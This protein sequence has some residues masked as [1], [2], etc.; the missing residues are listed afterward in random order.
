[1]KKEKIEE[2]HS[3][4]I[5]KTIEDLLSSLE[6]IIP[7]E[8]DKLKKFVS[9]FKE[10]FPLENTQNRGSAEALTWALMD[11]P[12][13]LYALGKNGSAIVELHGILEM[14]AT[15]KI[16]AFL[17]PPLKETIKSRV[18][19]R[20]TSEDLALILCGL[21]IWS[22]EDVKFVEKLKKLRNGF[23]HKNP[24]LISN[25]VCS[26]KEISMLDIDSVMGDINCVPLIVKTI[27]LLLKMVLSR[28][29]NEEKKVIEE[30][31]K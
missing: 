26:G 19:K 27:K 31:L 6:N 20:C 4:S 2:E 18:I 21:G 13:L 1:M 10:E 24:K 22:K 25:A 15:R 29:P 5:N 9:S 23:A 17:P 3:L 7:S 28:I 30:N 11:G 12:L 16:V 14:F 8:R